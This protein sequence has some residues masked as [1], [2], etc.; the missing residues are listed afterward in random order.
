MKIW[1]LALA[2]FAV[3][4]CALDTTLNEDDI[5]R[6]LITSKPDVN[7]A[8]AASYVRL[9]KPE[10]QARK[11]LVTINAKSVSVMDAITDVLPTHNVVPRDRNVNL[12]KEISVMA[13][14]MP[15][16]DYLKMLIGLTEYDF[17]LRDNTIYVSSMRAEQWNLASL[18]SKR[19]STSTVGR[20]QASGSASGDSTS[21]GGNNSESVITVINNDD[22][23]E[24]ML[25]GARAI[26]NV[27]DDDAI[28]QNAAPAMDSALTQANPT[29]MPGL[30]VSMDFPGNLNNPE[31]LRPY[32]AGVRRLGTI[33][34][35]GTPYRMQILDSW[36]QG[37]V[38]NAQRQVRMD[39]KAFDVSLN[40]A[41]G[42]GIDWTALYGVNS[43]SSISIGGQS[44]VEISGAGVWSIAA[45][46]VS[47]EKQWSVESMFNFLGRFGEVNIVNQPSLTVVNGSTAMISNG[48]VFSFVSS[49]E[50]THDAQGMQTITPIMSEL[51]VGLSL[52][53]TPRILEDD[54]ILIEVVPVISSVR[55][56]DDVTI[57]DW[58]F[59]TPRVA[60]QE[61][62]THVIAHSGETV[63]LG[64]LI[65]RR[66]AEQMSKVPWKDGTNNDAVNFLFSSVRNELERRELVLAI[67]P[68][69]LSN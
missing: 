13:N 33:S 34:A 28:R 62:S 27:Q 51:R 43:P 35:A 16:D 4:G 40:D 25:E 6:P 32:V 3:G 46:A 1:L 30:P 69:L 22:A 15:V 56:Y 58:K 65:T 7:R 9:I 31:R 49:V 68:Q 38:Y 10:T 36:L 52:T 45:A 53:V 18:S 42:R 48:D 2:I 8:S 14:R 67:T 12:R 39:I 54:R 55:G 20:Q 29:A 21:N 60:L 23:W 11:R 37:L 26:L 41:R 50:R 17:L 64:G 66:I 57:G 61:L 59:S 19:D 63:Q 24:Q 47:S 5:H 44:P